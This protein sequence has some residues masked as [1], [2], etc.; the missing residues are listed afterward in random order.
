MYLNAIIASMDK[1]LI[2]GS[3]HTDIIAEVKELP[4][5][6]E[7]FKV[8]NTYETVGGS[9]F[10]SAEIFHLF[11]FP[12][13][14]LAPVGTGVYGDKVQASMKEKGIPVEC[15]TPETD[16]CTY[17][18]KDEEG[19]ESVIFVPG[20]EYSFDHSYT[21]DVYPDEIDNLIVS[22]DL[23]AGDGA[24]DLLETIDDL[25]KPVYYILGERIEDI[26]EEA[27]DALFKMHPVLYLNE[28][29]AWYL[30][31]E[32]EKDLQKTS[33]LLYQLTNS[34]VVIVKDGEGTYYYEKDQSFL[35]PERKKINTL[36]HCGAFV[37]AR[38]AG[39]SVR[40]AL[41]LANAFA[42][43]NHGALPDEW[44]MRDI[45]QKLI[46]IITKK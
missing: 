9:G 35:V 32:K 30:S 1:T 11:G 38:N 33:A 6:N 19:N 21:E 41:V 44:D 3:V 27:H 23:L 20:A 7:D 24:S 34:P 29:E 17:H 36:F 8:N 10:V 45:K 4:K 22:G 42:T 5:G 40:D 16:G 43:A 31:H 37:C 13:D 15:Y 39:A 2:I 14:L 26:P 46:D 12:Y 28:E 18:L 25:G